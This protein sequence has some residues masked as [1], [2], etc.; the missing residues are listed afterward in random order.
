MLSIVTVCELKLLF[1]TLMKQH[2]ICPEC[3]LRCTYCNLVTSVCSSAALD[4]LWRLLISDY[5]RK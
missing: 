5:T 2:A 3:L 1:K 4:R